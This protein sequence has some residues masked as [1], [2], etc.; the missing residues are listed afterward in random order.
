VIG[1]E[2]VLEGRGAY[3]NSWILSMI[4]CCADAVLFIK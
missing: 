2:S 4:V 1:H 3:P